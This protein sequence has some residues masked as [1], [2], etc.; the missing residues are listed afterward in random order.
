[1]IVGSRLNSRRGKRGEAAWC[2]VSYGGMGGFRHRVKQMGLRGLMAL[3]VVGVLSGCVSRRMTV[4]SDPPGALVVVDG[5]EIG[6]SPVSVDFTYYGTR[7]ISLIKDGYETLT[8]MQPLTKPWYQYPGVE[9]VADNLKPG[10]KTDRQMFQYA[11]QP[12]RIVPNQELLQ[13]GEML[14]GEAR[15]GQ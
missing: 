11:L 7:E 3:A 5:R 12:A 8:V 2:V 15:I 6:Y 13:R 9:F 1:M 14:R 10:H 4:V